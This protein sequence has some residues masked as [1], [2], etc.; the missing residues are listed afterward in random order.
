MILLFGTLADP[1]VAA[2]CAGLVAR[3]I[4]FLLFD[5]RQ[6]PQ[7]IDLTWWIED[8]APGGMIRFG[9]RQVDLRA[10]RSVFSRHMAR[11]GQPWQKEKG[12]GPV[13]DSREAYHAL[14]AFAN[15]WPALVVNRPS[16]SASNAVKPYQQQ[17][18]ACHGFRVPRT[19][20]TTV[21]EEARRFYEECAGRV[22][23]KS[24]SHNSSIVR[25]VTPADL[26]RLHEVQHC[27]T[28]F[29]EYVAGVDLRVHAVGNR[30]FATEVMT[31]ATD[32]RY[33]GQEGADREMRGV[34]LPAEIEDRC[35]RLMGGLGLAL[36]GIDLRRTPEGEYYCF[37]VNP[38]PVFTFYEDHTG[39]RIGDAVVD[40][41]ARGTA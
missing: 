31:D 30:L 38:A 29:Q 18:I 39:Q 26:E 40:L 7:E 2:V 37:E 22:I 28:Q 35:H 20:V 25:R 24:I 12:D 34:G 3:E 11:A 32:Y 8:G 1:G 15:T 17:L 23:Y 9:S 10:V 6:Y 19:L 5:P 14:V 33:A 36:G 21:P 13:P 27:P 41:L 16:A 4:D